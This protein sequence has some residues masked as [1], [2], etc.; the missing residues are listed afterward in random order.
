MKH[1]CFILDSNKI[2]FFNNPITGVETVALNGRE[3][4]SKFSFF[5]GLHNLKINEE[6]YKL[7]V[8]INFLKAGGAS[9]SIYKGAAKLNLINRI[10][11]S[12]KLML[13]LKF[14]A[15]CIIGGV[16]GVYLGFYG[17]DLIFEH[18]H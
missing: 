12:E 3:V 14:A 16:I 7:Q 9:A 13:N 1:A 6:I 11:K 4:S 17:I 15:C 2:E 10:T 5:G 18:L 8:G